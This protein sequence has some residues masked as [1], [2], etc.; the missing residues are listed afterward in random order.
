M[1]PAARARRLAYWRACGRGARPH[2]RSRRRRGI[3]PQRIVGRGSMP[4]ARSRRAA[5]STWGS[6]AGVA[7][8]ACA[9]LAPPTARASG[10]HPFWARF[11]PTR[12]IAAGVARV[13]PRLADRFITSGPPHDDGSR[14]VHLDL[15]RVF[16]SRDTAES[17]GDGGDGGDAAAR[18]SSSRAGDVR[19]RVARLFPGGITRLALPVHHHL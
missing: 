2:R 13:H 5:R 4:E 10:T 17:R 7:I 11:G 3:E 8:D 12:V 19:H 6:N 14:L 15:E 1:A 9:P 18:L 16:V